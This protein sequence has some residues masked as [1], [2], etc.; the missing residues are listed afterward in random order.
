MKR[1]DYYFGDMAIISWYNKKMP[2]REINKYTTM[3]GPLTEIKEFNM[4]ATVRVREDEG[5]IESRPIGFERWN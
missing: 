4:T 2:K 3:Y 5:P 1:F